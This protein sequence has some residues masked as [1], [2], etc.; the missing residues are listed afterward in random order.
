M[1]FLEAV[2]RFFIAWQKTAFE[3]PYTDEERSAIAGAG[4]S[5]TRHGIPAPCETTWLLRFAQEIRDRIREACN[6][7]SLPFSLGRGLTE[8]TTKALE[9]YLAKIEVV[10]KTLPGL[11]SNYRASIEAQLEREMWACNRLPRDE[12]GNPEDAEPPILEL[13]SSVM[14][15]VPAAGPETVPT[16]ATVPPAGKSEPPPADS[17][18]P[19]ALTAVERAMQIFLRDTRQTKVEIARQ[20][21]CHP[22]VLSR[23][24][25]FTRLWDAHH[26]TV[27][28]GSK[29]KD[30]TMEAE[31]NEESA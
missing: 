21:G 18:P 8:R 10:C 4:Q 13:L 23:E 11:S 14:A 19:A 25:P 7:V 15:L 27:P 17:T 30:G 12:E 5:T 9:D 31:A 22:S 2:K 28:K 16:D 6:G 24:G 3:P 1:Q 29:A 26:G 20:A